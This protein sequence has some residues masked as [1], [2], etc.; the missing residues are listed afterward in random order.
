MLSAMKTLGSFFFM[1]VLMTSLTGCLFKEPVF[2]QG[3]SKIDPVLN[4]VWASEGENGD[5]RKMEFAV[6]APLDDERYLLNHPSAEKG[7][8]FYEARLLKVQERNLLQ[9]RLLASF[10]DGI[11]KPDDERYTL[12]W[13]EKGVEGKTLKVRALGGSGVKEKG[14]AE[15]KRLL[16]APGTDWNTLFGDAAVYRK[17]KDK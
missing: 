7:S 3:F 17:L 12:L 13:L 16:E 15:V 2:E 4:G 9:L 6:C 10:H 8:L 14:A 1:V 11:T 5:P